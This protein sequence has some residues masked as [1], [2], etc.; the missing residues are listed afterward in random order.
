MTFN[1]YYSKLKTFDNKVKRFVT[2]DGLPLI[3]ECE[4]IERKEADAVGFALLGIGISKITKDNIDE[5]LFRVRF[6]EKVYGHALIT[7]GTADELVSTDKLRRAFQHHVG[8]EINYGK[9]LSRHKFVLN[10]ARGIECDVSY[11]LRKEISN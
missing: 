2:S 10:L 5:I 7:F 9:E 8:L 11:A 4:S 6:S 1:V 3:D